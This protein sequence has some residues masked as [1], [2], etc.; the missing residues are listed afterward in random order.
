MDGHAIAELVEH[1]QRLLARRAYPL[2]QGRVLLARQVQQNG[3]HRREFL[4][5]AHPVAIG[6][7]HAGHA[8]LAAP[9]CEHVSTYL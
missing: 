8:Q 9:V 4:P 5:H 6:L 2:R 3:L 1:P 7:A